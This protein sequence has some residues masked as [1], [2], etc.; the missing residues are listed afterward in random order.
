MNPT[1][2]TVLITGG[3][4]GIGLALAE[5]F[6]QRN[7]TVII[8]G[9][10]GEKL[11]AAKR[12]LPDVVTMVC[13]ITRSQDLAELQA[14]ISARF[15]QL[16]ILINNAGVQIPMD[17]AGVGVDEAAIEL[18]IQTNLVA[19]IKLTNRLL[20]LLTAQKESAIVFVG[21]ALGRVPKHGAPVYCAS[22][23]G[24]HSFAQSLRFQLSGSDTKVME[25]VPD[26]VATDM[27]SERQNVR[28]VTAETVAE[29]VLS[30][31]IRNAKEILIGRTRLLFGLHRW[32]PAVAES[33]IN[34]HA[35]KYPG[36]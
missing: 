18:E 28:K 10:D 29:N 23:A 34:R 33:I 12:Q 2:N 7:N 15:P 11:A 35:D 4:S 30:G 27:T 6:L 31:L 16:N 14:Q 5:Q 8:C 24:I 1:N 19:H 21:S 9:R 22:K 32:V 25:V 20:S 3:A 17:F 13:D 36:N 26:L